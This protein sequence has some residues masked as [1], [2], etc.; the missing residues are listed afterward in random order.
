MSRGSVSGG[1]TSHKRRKKALAIKQSLNAS[2][3]TEKYKRILRLCLLSEVVQH[4]SNVKFGPEIYCATKKRDT[5]VFEGFYERVEE[6]AA[7]LGKVGSL[8][9]AK[10]SVIE[11]DARQS[12][13]LMRRRSF[14][15]C[16]CSP[17]Y[18]TEHDYTRNSR[19]ALA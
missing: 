17:P 8:P 10:S 13:S 14:T 1:W 11:G 2:R 12:S 19:L 4:A 3:F 9:H 5:V 15:H 6:V 7:D 16:I 18:P